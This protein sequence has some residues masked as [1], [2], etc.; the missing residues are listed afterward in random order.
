MTIW[1]RVACCISKATR[2]RPRARTHTNT[3]THTILIAFPR[4]RWLLKR[5]SIL[6]YTARLVLKAG[7]TLVITQVKELL[8]LLCFVLSGE[9]IKSIKWMGVAS[10]ISI[11]YLRTE[12]DPVSGTLCL[13]KNERFEKT[14]CKHRRICCLNI[15]R[16]GSPYSGK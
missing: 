5:A 6:R 1:W 16:G 14:V 10:I 7:S 11:F 3:H 15:P 2:P 8:N 13:N 4:P 9:G 12:I